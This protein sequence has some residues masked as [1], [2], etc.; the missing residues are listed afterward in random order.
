PEVDALVPEGRH[1][2]GVLRRDAGGAQAVRDEQD[3][4][5]GSVL[6]CAGRRDERTET[7]QQPSKTV[8][9]ALRRP[10]KRT[11]NGPTPV[12]RDPADASTRSYSHCRNVSSSVRNSWPSRRIAIICSPP[13]ARAG[14]RRPAQE[15]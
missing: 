12:T 1:S 11:S 7:R 15:E 3:D 10:M 4:V 6:L 8:H 14:G 9:G 5:V 2:R 13:S